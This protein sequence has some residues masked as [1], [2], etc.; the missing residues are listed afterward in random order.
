MSPRV[1]KNKEDKIGNW[2]SSI[3]SPCLSLIFFFQVFKYLEFSWGSGTIFEKSSWTEKVSISPSSQR[4]EFFESWS[5]SILGD[6]FST[7]SCLS[8]RRKISF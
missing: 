8:L 2:H 7:I 3:S 1:G 4:Y 5:R 6:E